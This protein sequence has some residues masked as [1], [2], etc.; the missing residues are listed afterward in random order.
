MAKFNFFLC[1]VFVFCIMCTKQTANDDTVFSSLNGHVYIMKVDRIA[2]RPGVGFP[3]DD[4]DE[5]YYTVTNEDITHEITFS[6]D[7]QLVTIKPGPVSGTKTKDG[8]VSK[9]YDLGNSLFAGGRL[10]IWITNRNIEAEYTVYGS[11]VP[12]IRSE[13]GKLE[14]KVQ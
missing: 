5:S 7:G 1:L 4:L 11:G 12:V 10:V 14:P 3:G 13:R 8:K 2:Q 6:E 9:Y